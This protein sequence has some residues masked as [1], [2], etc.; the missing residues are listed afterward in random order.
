M[1]ATPI[2][3]TGAHL[4]RRRFLQASGTGLVAAAV[5]AACGD[6]SSSSS[7]TTTTVHPDTAG[8]VRILRTASSIELL[9][10]EI[11]TKVVD[12]KLVQSPQ[13][14]EIVKQLQANHKEQAELFRSETLKLK[15]EAF[16]QPN[17]TLARQ[18]ESKLAGLRDEAGILG[19][20]LE[21]ERTAAAT[22]Q[23]YVGQ[24]SDDHVVLNQVV[25]SVGGAAARAAAVLAGVL[26][27]PAVPGALATTTGAIAAGTG[28]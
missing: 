27:Q 16:T 14:I 23:S 11:Y 18:L 1:P 22:Y 25:M 13:G 24:F 20:A 21:T 12:S 3:E 2:S 5:L 8:D 26:G 17:G 9:H 7:S 6:S 4:S 19:L 10:V 28:V 15:G